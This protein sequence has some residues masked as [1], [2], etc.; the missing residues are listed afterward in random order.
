M[1]Q[2]LRYWLKGQYNNKPL[3]TK[4]LFGKNPESLTLNELRNRVYL[5]IILFWVIAIVF[6]LIWFG[7]QQLESQIDFCMSGELLS[8]CMRSLDSCVMFQ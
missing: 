7:T 3:L 2:K 8:A 6:V 5:N 1:I 4:F